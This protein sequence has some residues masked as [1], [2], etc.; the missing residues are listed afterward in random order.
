MN[1]VHCK[2]QLQTQLLWLANLHTHHTMAS[3][4]APVSRRF[5]VRDWDIH[6]EA[7]YTQCGLFHSHSLQLEDFQQRRL[8]EKEDGEAFELVNQPTL[9]GE[10]S[11]KQTK[12]AWSL[13]LEERPSAV[14]THKNASSKRFHRKTTPG[15]NECEPITSTRSALTTTSFDLES[16]IGEGT[17]ATVW[18]G[19]CKTGGSYVAIKSAKVTGHGSKLDAVSA[20]VA[21]FH[22]LL[23]FQ[24]QPHIVQG[25]HL[26]ASMQP[27]EAMIIMEFCKTSVADAL[28]AM[29]FD[30]LQPSQRCICALGVPPPVALQQMCRG[31]SIMHHKGVL[32]RD[33]KPG[34]MLVRRH[35]ELVLAD[36]GD[37]ASVR[38]AAE[39]DKLVG[40]SYYRAPEIFM[41]GHATPHSDVWAIC[42]SLSVTW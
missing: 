11:F 6:D 15:R 23:G 22:A 27:F 1:A 7:W 20:C 13:Q 14:F 31:L 2:K 36:L 19:R 33:L 12:R 28:K 26:V 25:L 41:G 30:P 42:P 8:V 24:G 40:T 21:E 32:H 18:K 4:Q 37:A 10:V 9:V 17:F 29:E 16:A 34:N 3:Q 39:D 35:G 38:E 5:Q